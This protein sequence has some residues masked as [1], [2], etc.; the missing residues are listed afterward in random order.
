MTESIDINALIPVEKQEK[1]DN[2]LTWSVGVCEVTVTSD[3]EYQHAASLLRE[4][5]SAKDA[6]DDD[7]KEIVYPYKQRTKA[8]DDK[9]R[10]V[11][12][13][14][15][16]AENVLRRSVSDW[17][18]KKERERLEA[19]RKLELEAAE[20]RR[21]AE[22]EAAKAA[23][24]AE[25]L[26]EAGK[27]AQAEKAEAKAQIA[28]MQAQAIVA[29]IVEAAPKASGISYRKS[30]EVEITDYKKAVR[31]MAADPVLSAFLEINETKLKRHVANLGGDV[32]LPEGLRAYEDTKT[33]VSGKR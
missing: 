33:V 5:K 13:K 23:E 28:T 20:A 11:R 7:R 4:I 21:K 1:I 25:A 16:N 6:L 19:Q 12:I 10:E 14:I 3:D 9:Y 17:A 22:A 32:V 24:K 26:R 29:P 2:F 31:G 8:V 27:Q 18:A 15:E 30:W